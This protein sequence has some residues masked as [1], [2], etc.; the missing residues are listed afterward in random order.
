MEVPR[1]ADLGDIVFSQRFAQLLN[2]YWLAIA[3]PFSVTGNFTAQ[4]NVSLALEK[5]GSGLARNT[6]AQLQTVETV[7]VCHTV[8]LVV[9]LIGSL[10]MLLAGIATTT[11][12]LKRKGPE[13][14]D[15]FA[16]MLR[17]SPH[18]HVETGPSTEDGSDKV[19]RLQKSRVMLG[20]VCPLGTT[21]F[22][23]L[24]TQTNGDG[25][26]HVQRLRGDRVYQ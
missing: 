20:D 17:D 19:R 25:I 11:L 8:W 23:A 2:T 21:G 5:G 15:S 1:I 26:D 4:N 6:T 3:A 10:V 9:L 7:L 22:V 16:S 13:I 18:V 24:A 12:N 14:L